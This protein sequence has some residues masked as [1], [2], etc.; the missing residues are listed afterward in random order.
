MILRQREQWRQSEGSISV[1][2]LETSSEIYIAAQSSALP[3]YNQCAE[4]SVYTISHNSLE[5][6][7]ITDLPPSY[8]AAI[9]MESQATL[10]EHSSCR[11]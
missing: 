1:A 4:C 11:H 6:M 7:K 10:N 8:E 5:V 3:T 9:Q 2:T